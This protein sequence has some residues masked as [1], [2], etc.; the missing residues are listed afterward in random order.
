[1]EGAGILLQLA[2]LHSSL[3]FPLATTPPHCTGLAVRVGENRVVICFCE[4]SPPEFITSLK[5]SPLN[6]VTLIIMLL[7]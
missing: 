5:A 7:A 2:V 1:M 4:Q 6:T 3:W